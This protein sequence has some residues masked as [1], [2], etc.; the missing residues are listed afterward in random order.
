THASNRYCCGDLCLSGDSRGDFCNQSLHLAYSALACCR[1]EVGFGVFLEGEKVPINTGKPNRISC[2]RPR[3]P[4]TDANDSF[5]R[6]ANT[7]LRMDDIRVAQ[8][9][10]RVLQVDEAPGKGSRQYYV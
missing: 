3:S 1:M 2:V 8:P 5:G 6:N 9:G 4:S 10:M 7:V